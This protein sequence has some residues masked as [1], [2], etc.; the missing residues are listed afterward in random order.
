MD[1]ADAFGKAQHPLLMKILNKNSADNII[2]N[3]E[4][5]NN[6]PLK[7]AWPTW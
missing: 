6:F 7:L 4:T 5:Q 1:T 2:P 3:F